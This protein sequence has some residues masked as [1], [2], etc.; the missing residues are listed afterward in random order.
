MPDLFL[1]SYKILRVLKIIGLWI[2]GISLFLMMLFI[3]GD[4]FSRNILAKSIPGGYE[5]VGKYFMPLTVFPGL[6]FA[7]GTGIFPRITML[8]TKFSMFKQRMIVITLLIFEGIFFFLIT[9]YGLLY[10]IESVNQGLAFPAGGH[11]YPLY[12]LIFLVPI[13]FGI[14][15]IEIVFLIIKNIISD[16]VSLSIYEESGVLID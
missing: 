5:L 2:S 8:V 12:P 14:I 13:F 4:V 10:A 6:A 7:Y 11:I 16:E 15:I 9:Y 3:A 1:R